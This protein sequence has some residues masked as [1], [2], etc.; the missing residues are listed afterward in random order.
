[1]INVSTRILTAWFQLLNGNISVPVYR[2]EAPPTEEGN[3]VLIRVESDANTPNKHRFFSNPVV[4]TDVVTRFAGGG[5]INDELAQEIDEEIGVLLFGEPNPTVI[6]N[7]PAQEDIQII[8]VERQSATYL[9]EDDGTDRYLR[10]L[11]RNVHRV[12]QLIIES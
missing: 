5:R 11:T 7:L 3:Y 12:E 9:P 10:I 8:S 4:I 2:Y 1:M 6:H